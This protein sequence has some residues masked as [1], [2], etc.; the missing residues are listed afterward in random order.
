MID[1]SLSNNLTGTRK[2]LP[3]QVS[4]TFG[5]DS[6]VFDDD[7]LVSCAGLVPVM[8][9]AEQPAYRSCWTTRFTSQHPG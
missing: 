3:V 5:P 4:H 2:A 8:V 1:V 9:L 7:N 6:A